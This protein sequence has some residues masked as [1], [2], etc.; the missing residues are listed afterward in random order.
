LEGLRAIHKIR[1]SSYNLQV[2]FYGKA[3]EIT[4]IFKPAPVETKQPIYELCKLVDPGNITKYERI[5][6]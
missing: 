3:D 4:Q 6:N 2:F 1:P 5:M